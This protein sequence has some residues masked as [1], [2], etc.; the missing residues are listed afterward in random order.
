M[1]IIKIDAS[2]AS[3][4]QGLIK[5]AYLPLLN[6]YHDEQQNPANKSLERIIENITNAD[7]YLLKKENDYIGYIKINKRGPS[8][9]S[10][11]DLCVKCD[12]QGNGYGQFFLNG[13]EKL[14]NH[15]TKWSLITIFE[16]KKDCH[17]YE[18][19]GYIQQGIISEVTPNMHFVLYIKDLV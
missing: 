5:D 4:V 6:K 9:Y 7:A 15:A 16:E 10:V 2:Y 1:Q 13:V 8:E 17:L 12:C 14:Y 3:I 18:K 11:S 19:L